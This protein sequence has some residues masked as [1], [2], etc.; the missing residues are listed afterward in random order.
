MQAFLRLSRIHGVLARDITCRKFQRCATVS[1]EESGQ[2]ALH[3]PRRGTLPMKPADARIDAEIGPLPVS[4]LIRGKRTDTMPP[5]MMYFSSFCKMLSH[6]VIRARMQ[7]RSQYRRY[8][9]MTLGAGGA[10][11]ALPLCAARLNT[12]MREQ[13]YSIHYRAQ[14][15]HF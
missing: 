10:L 13:E 2:C 11:V 12:E 15:A 6:T 3:M 8:R 7:C 14:R 4:A 9:L 5:P 1:A